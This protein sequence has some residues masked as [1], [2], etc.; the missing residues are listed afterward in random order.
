MA[1]GILPGAAAK[2]LHPQWERGHSWGAGAARRPVPP[3]SIRPRFLRAASAPG[4]AAIYREAALK[5]DF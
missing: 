4:G 3:Y 5:K 1:V 2:P